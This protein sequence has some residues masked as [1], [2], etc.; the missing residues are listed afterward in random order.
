MPQPSPPDADDP[1]ELGSFLDAPAEQGLSLDELSRAYADLLDRGEDPYDEVAGD[2]LPL[3]LD[4]EQDAQEADDQDATAPAGPDA[5]EI[6]PL[7]ILEAMFFVG[8]PRNEPL[9]SEKVASLM[10]GVRPHEVDEMVVELNQA[11]EREGCPYRIE[12]AGAGYRMAL[13]AEFG[14]LRD[15][16]YGRVKA[17]KLSQAAID[18]LAIVAYK[19]PMTREAVD[20]LRGK[21]SGGLL[22]QLVRRQLL[23]IERTEQKPR[24]TLFYTT[25]RFL[26]LF[27]LESLKDLPK[28]QD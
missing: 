14:S 21:P 28:S 17:A 1:L 12:S 7:S 6:T 5:C 19:Q 11:Y 10:R 23:R 27:G 2:E 13:R 15:R 20:Q 26:Q 24:T 3:D 18:V 25:D 16:F 4:D 8:H 9:T 22:S